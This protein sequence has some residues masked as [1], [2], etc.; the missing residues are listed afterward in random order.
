MSEA[1][2]PGYRP[3]TL[4]TDL[5]QLTMAQGYVENGMA[6]VRASFYAF[7]RENPFQG[8]F[9]V[10]AGL[11]QIVEL[12]EGFG[13]TDDEI[14][15][16]RSL[17]AP[18]GRRMFSDTFLD[19]LTDLRFTCDVEAVPEG[20][21]V[22]PQMPLVRVEGPIV[23]CQLIETALLNA[24]NFQTLIATKAA[25][26]KLAAA[27][28]AVSEF[29]LRRAQGPDGGISASR[30]SCVGGADS[31]S[32][33]LAGLIHDIPVSGTHAHSWVMAFPT[34][35]EA[36]RAYAASQPTA[37]TLL[38]DTY[39]V[40]KGVENAIQVG[41]EMEARGER[42]AAIRIDSG[43]L[44]WLSKLA[45]RRLDEAGLDY[46]KIVASNDLDEYTMLSLV[47]QGA[48][49]DAWGVGTRLAT[50]WEQPALGGVYKLSA[51]KV[52][53]RWEPR[54]KVSEATAKMTVPGR[55]GLRRYRREDGSIA[56]DMVYD[57]DSPPGDD[58]IIVDPLDA[59]RRK[60]LTGRTYTELLEPQFASGVFV[61]VRESVRDARARAIE[62]VGSLDPSITRFLRP[63]PYPAGIERGLHEL[64]SALTF[65]ARGLS[66]E[67]MHPSAEAIAAAE[68]MFRG[69]D[70]R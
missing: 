14:D 65:A 68:R 61:G 27:G 33:T 70:E 29:G 22:F 53:G 11:A 40:E 3:S 57:I 52:D 4:L 58:A 55:V 50:S 18:A 23:Q 38:V 36:F 37:C 10:A 67:D 25:R 21:V 5:Y 17:E 35:L 13:F 24:L 6:E 31:T 41:R 54:M 46:V 1:A 49:I 60:D 28:G 63:H 20:T 9:T 51:L 30:A 64:R 69:E 16:L 44:A 7:F 26:V 15:Y 48:R 42:L 34:E 8:G 2:A 59:S 66:P 47:E 19:Y 12:M 43:D 39:D 45:R 62:Q 56:G 32:N